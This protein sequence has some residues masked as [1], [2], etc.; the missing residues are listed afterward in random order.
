MSAS[1]QVECKC[2][3]CLFQSVVSKQSLMASS[4]A[5]EYFLKVRVVVGSLRTRGV[6]RG[7]RETRLWSD[8]PEVVVPWQCMHP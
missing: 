2:E 3:L 4:A 1:V 6:Y 5:R 8:F 7:W